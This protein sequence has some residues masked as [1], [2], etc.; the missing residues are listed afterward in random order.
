M[1]QE[2]IAKA[3]TDAQRQAFE[4]EKKKSEDKGKKVPNSTLTQS[5]D[6]DSTF[7]QSTGKENVDDSTFR[8]RSLHLK[9]TF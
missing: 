3:Y 2:N 6:N 4:E 7:I 5:T 1:L 8:N 9:C